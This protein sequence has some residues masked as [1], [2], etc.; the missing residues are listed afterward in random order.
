MSSVGMDMETIRRLPVADHPGD[1]GEL[2]VSFLDFRSEARRALEAQE[3]R[4]AGV[5]TK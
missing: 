3:A 1:A 2:C 5:G 4:E